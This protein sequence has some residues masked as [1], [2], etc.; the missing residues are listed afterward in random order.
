MMDDQDHGHETREAARS[1]ARRRVSW[2]R[3]ALSGRVATLIWALRIYAVGMLAVIAL[4]ITRL[5]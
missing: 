5:I 1:A 3:R 2:P 4:Q